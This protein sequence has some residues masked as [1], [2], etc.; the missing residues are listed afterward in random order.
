[1]MNEQH[2]PQDDP[3]TP[4]WMDELQDM[5]ERILGES[6]SGSACD[7]VHPI[8]AKWY[9]DTLERMDDEPV[10]DRSAVWQAVSC[11]ATEIM[12]DAEAD[13]SL[14]PMFDSVDEDMLGMWVEYILMMGRAM[15]ASLRDGDLDDL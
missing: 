6:D 4:R 7:Q 12:M 15:E 10:E 9:D 3:Q 1:M 8:I 5:A 2:N 11:L 13:D 14:R